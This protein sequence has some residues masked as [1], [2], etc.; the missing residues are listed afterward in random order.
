MCVW[1]LHKHYTV[2]HCNWVYLSRQPVFH[3]E[4]ARLTISS[5]VP[6]DPTIAAQ[7]AAIAAQVLAFID[8]YEDALARNAPEDELTD[9]CC[10]ASLVCPTNDPK[11][12]SDKDCTSTRLILTSRDGLC[13]RS[14]Q[15]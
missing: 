10:R 7:A 12:T 1:C 2:G 13:V 14:S 4:V 8:A 6:D 15:P 3:L 11:I 5:Q 9:V